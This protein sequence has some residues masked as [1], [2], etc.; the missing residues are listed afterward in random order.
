MENLKILQHLNQKYET[1]NENTLPLCAAENVMSDFSKLP[2]SSSMQ[3]R[4]IMGGILDL[5]KEDNFMESALLFEYYE[6]LSKIGKELYGADY[7][8]GRTLT[9]M[10]ALTT[11]LMSAFK[12]G[13][14]VLI[15]SSDVGG[16]G[17][18]PIICNRLGLKYEYLPYNYE[19]F[20]FD[21][22]K[23]NQTIKSGQIAGII[24]G[25]SDVL[26]PPKIQQLELQDTILIYDATQ[27]LG[28]IAFDSK[29][30]PLCCMPADN[31]IIL[32][33][34]THKTIP[35]PS[36]GL[37][38]AK[39]ISFAQEIDKKINPNY[40][41]NIQMHQVLSLIYTLIE[42]QA[43][44]KEYMKQ[45]VRNTEMLTTMLEPYFNILKKKNCYSQTH[46]IHFHIEESEIDTFYKNAIFHS[47]TL[48]KRNKKIYQNSGI[49][50]GTQEITRYGYGKNELS[51]IA[52]I[53]NLLKV[54]QNLKTDK[55]I[56]SIL[57]KLVCNKE[58][59]YCF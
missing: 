58:I 14:K 46:Q 30:N 53:L 12:I 44:G 54:K 45:M 15:S 48:N 16:H 20:D 11:L 59:H 25:L 31:K 43:Y 51:Q 57:Q 35:G 39:N 5:Q 29:Q 28:L 1:Y 3:E 52:N 32:L 24:I 27:T 13:D 56:N 2:L 37:I 41:R 50:I 26:Y 19:E 33:G 55:E 23:I 6:L 17:S 42:F 40:I 7:T 21:Y 8:D 22:Q 49:R 36:C 34:A 9:G 18:I 38:M 47:V 10:N 4:Y